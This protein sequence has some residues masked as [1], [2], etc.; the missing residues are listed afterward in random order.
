M[1]FSLLH[2]KQNE[3]CIQLRSFV[4][5]ISNIGFGPEATH[6]HV[7]GIHADMPISPIQFP[8]KHPDFIL[9]NT[10]ADRYISNDQIA[11]SFMRE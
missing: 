6:T 2:S 7:V 5:L 11:P 9:A 4:N 10:E 3:F 8:L 1:T